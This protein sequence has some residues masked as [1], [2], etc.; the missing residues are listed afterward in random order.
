MSAL[1]SELAYW[2]RERFPRAQ[3][4]FAPLLSGPGWSAMLDP[5]DG[6]P[7]QAEGETYEAALEALLNKLATKHS[8]EDTPIFVRRGRAA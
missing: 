4:I 2:L 7:V 3:L 8:D 6:W 1:E 5:E